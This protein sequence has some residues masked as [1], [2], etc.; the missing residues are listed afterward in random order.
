MSLPNEISEQL[1]A[2]CAM[3]ATAVA[4]LPHLDQRDRRL[5]AA[6]M[7]GIARLLDNSSEYPSSSIAQEM[8]TAAAIV[9]HSK[10]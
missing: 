6:R 7:R 5:L 2:L 8:N 1:A 9:E 3:L 4:P 10:P